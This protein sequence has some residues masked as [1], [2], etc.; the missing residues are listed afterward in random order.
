MEEAK[1]GQII[2]VIC[3]HRSEDDQNQDSIK[4]SPPCPFFS[5]GDIWLKDKCQLH[6]QNSV[7]LKLTFLLM[8]QDIKLFNQVLAH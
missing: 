2:Q 8:Y 1:K 6:I 4:G 3:F 5:M 7:S